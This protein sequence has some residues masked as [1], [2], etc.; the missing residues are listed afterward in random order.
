MVLHAW[1]DGKVGYPNGRRNV[2]AVP[3]AFFGGVPQAG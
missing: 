3:L 2:F 1:I